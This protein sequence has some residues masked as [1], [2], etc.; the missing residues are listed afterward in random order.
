M[1]SGK[2]SNILH[3]AKQHGVAVVNPQDLLVLA[4][5]AYKKVNNGEVAPVQTEEVVPKPRPFDADIHAAAPSTESSAADTQIM[6]IDAAESQSFNPTAFTKAIPDNDL[7]SIGAKA[8]ETLL[9][10]KPPDDA[11]IIQLIV[12]AVKHIDPKLGWVIDGFPTTL[13]QAVDLETALTGL[14]WAGLFC[15][16]IFSSV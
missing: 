13:S 10:G 11:L 9:L 16:V 4:V 15:I 12:L 8:T 6:T 7:V 5:Q 1:F 2:S 3:F 14:S